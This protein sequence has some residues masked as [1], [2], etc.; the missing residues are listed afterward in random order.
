MILAILNDAMER[1]I[2]GMVPS[3]IHR[4]ALRKGW[5]PHKATLRSRLWTMNSIENKLD[6]VPGT[7]L[8]RMK[9]L[10]GM[11]YPGDEKPADLLSSGE[12]SAGSVQPAGD[13]EP[14][15]EVAHDNID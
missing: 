4:A 11:P 8:Y 5:N 14:V 1:K 13:G 10:P 12:Q 7:A 6:K 9:P 2:P 3:D 15:Q